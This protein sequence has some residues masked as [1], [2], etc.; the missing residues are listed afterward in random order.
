M[1]EKGVSGKKNQEDEGTQGWIAAQERAWG[2]SST[3]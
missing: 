2:M 1:A 3:T